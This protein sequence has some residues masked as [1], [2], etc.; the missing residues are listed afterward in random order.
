MLWDEE[1]A[2]LYPE[3]SSGGS[4]V[5]GCEEE[6]EEE[7]PGQLEHQL[8]L[9]QALLERELLQRELCERELEELAQLPK[10]GCSSGSCRPWSLE[11]GKT[12]EDGE[13][14]SDDELSERDC[15]RLQRELFEH[16]LEARLADFDDPIGGWPGLTPSSTPLLEGTSRSPTEGPSSAGPQ[17][18]G[19]LATPRR[20]AG[21]QRG[22]AWG[23][24]SARRQSLLLRALGG[25]AA[26]PSPPWSASGCRAGEPHVG[27]E[28]V[29]RDLEVSLL[30][31]GHVV[32]E[33]Q[34][35]DAE[36]VLAGISPTERE[37]TMAWL[38]QACH[39]LFF[40]EAVL[41]GA[42]HLFD[43]Y[44]ATLREPMP[45][46][47]LH[48]LILAVVSTS[49]KMHGTIELEPPLPEVVSHLGRRQVPPEAVFRK[50][51]EV[52]QA[53]AFEVSTPP[54]AE[55]LEALLVRRLRPNPPGAAAGL[56]ADRPELAAVRS[57]SSFVLQLSLLEVGLHHRFPHTVLA[58]GAIYV[59]LWHCQAGPEEA[60]ALLRD[61]VVACQCGGGE[62]ADSP[63]SG[64]QA[65]R[66]PAREVRARAP[67]AGVI[68][69][70]PDHGEPAARIHPEE[71][72]RVVHEQWATALERRLA[73]APEEAV[74]KEEP[75]EAKCLDVRSQPSAA[76]LTLT[77]SPAAATLPDRGPGGIDASPP[78]AD[79]APT[80]VEADDTVVHEAL[81]C[82]LIGTVQRED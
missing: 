51:R 50:E 61:V 67:W 75:R 11:V 43:R 27:I 24:R 4:S 7:G 15:E 29:A 82:A 32:S 19:A 6:E 52:L 64:S 56:A 18:A 49:L 26:E 57:L 13:E 63:G 22:T 35:P 68:Q 60:R 80:R 44:S 12:C 81:R 65:G 17:A 3:G 28:D 73:G 25:G 77:R 71:A 45:R 38:M 72:E 78:R 58:A 2:R 9:Q 74:G 79:G 37:Q 46:E 54:V 47:E 76:V 53:L 59:A 70:I 48:V 5:A 31:A 8:E 20:G 16:E 10:D 21:R 33:R 42:A 14:A 34:R 41:F 40:R 1:P 69:E 39:T 23:P 30:Q 36:A 66:P 62:H 55:L